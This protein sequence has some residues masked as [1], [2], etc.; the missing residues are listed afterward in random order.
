MASPGPRGPSQPPQTGGARAKIAPR[1][2]PVGAVRRCPG[3]TQLYRWVGPGRRDP[4]RA[5]ADLGDVYRLDHTGPGRV[6]RAGRRQR[7][8]VGRGWNALPADGQPGHEGRLRQFRHCLYPCGDGRFRGDRGFGAGFDR[9]IG[10]QRRRRHRSFGAH[11]ADRPSG[12]QPTGPGPL[13]GY[14]GCRGAPGRFRGTAG[15]L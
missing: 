13:S 10:Q 4:R 14:R 8:G 3:N 12:R 5:Q 15:R 6:G 2:R 9:R 7:R 1:P 11:R